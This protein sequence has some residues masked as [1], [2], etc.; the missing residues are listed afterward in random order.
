MN[1]KIDITKALF[2]IKLPDIF[3]EPGT[4]DDKTVILKPLLTL[5][6][7]MRP[8]YIMETYYGTYENDGSMLM[9]YAM[10]QKLSDFY[11][12][13]T[14]EVETGRLYCEL[15]NELSEKWGK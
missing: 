11:K 9:T 7:M 14:Y 5:D 13:H 6:D 1:N 10:V 12:Q 8:V 2:Y 4:T 3:E 15:L